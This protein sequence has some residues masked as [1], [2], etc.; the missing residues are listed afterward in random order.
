MRN[1]AVLVAVIMFGWIYYI[2]SMAENDEINKC[3]FEWKIGLLLLSFIL[4]FVEQ[5]FI[6]IGELTLGGRTPVMILILIEI[7]DAFID[8]KK[9]DRKISI[10]ITNECAECC[11]KNK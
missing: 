4:A 2:Y 6:V 9:E 11:H 10:K 7:M 3:A 5:E 8:K 1:L